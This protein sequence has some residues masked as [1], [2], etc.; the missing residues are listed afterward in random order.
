MRT[1]YRWIGAVAL[2][3]ASALAHAH[4][5]APAL[6][7]IS[8]EG[9]G[10]YR[11]L[12]R[13]STL[14][15]SP[16]PPRP[17]FPP[18]CLASDVPEL[19]EEAAGAVSLRWTLQCAPQGLAGTRI[20]I[21]H[22][23]AS[24]INVI[25]R[26]V[27][28]DGRELQALIDARQSDLTLPGRSADATTAPTTVSL[29]YLQLGAE[30]LWFGPDHLLFLLGLLL[31]VRAPGKRLLTLTAFTLG[32]SV[33]LTLAALE[34]M[35]VPEAPM[36]LGI[37]LSLV[38]LARELLRAQPSLLGRW[39]AL[40]ALSFG[41]L[42]GLG[43]AGALRDIGLPRDDVITA[44]LAFNIGIELAQ[45]TVLLA[46]MLGAAVLKG[47]GHRTSR[48]AVPR[49]WSTV[50]PAYGIGTLSAFWCFERLGWMGAF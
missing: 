17:E 16:Q 14:Q 43:F 30:H 4:P 31:L 1:R 10:E 38:V 29:R 39:P 35:T 48:L 21:S 18:H 37:A 45:V 46:V 34:L 9:G 24:G 2:W 49:T 27:D 15:R 44:L 6:L 50:M 7:E 5:L 25:L 3:M 32:H 26:Y 28:A 12:W 41:L 19:R 8:A 33:T 40:M 42:H 47:L 36:E 23:A 13:L 11:V 22:L 20:G